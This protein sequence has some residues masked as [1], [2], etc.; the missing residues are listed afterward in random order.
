MPTYGFNTG[1]P[2]G[3]QSS[4][5]IYVKKQVRLD[6]LSFDQTKMFKLGNVAVAAV[7]NRLS[8]AQGP[9]DTAAK[10]L[11]KRYAI[12]KTKRGKGNRRNL[13]L[14]GDMLR[15]F[16]VRTV[17]ENRARAYVT[18]RSTSK[19]MWSKAKR[20]RFVG[21]E[22]KVKA[23][24]MQKIEPWMVLSPKNRASVSE[25]ARRILREMAKRLTVERWLG[26]K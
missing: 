18:G 12:W 2:Y 9:N 7:K 13:S 10:P 15:N 23:W 26:G 1:G 17:S 3:R 4:V 6:R 16:Q 25:A 22:N 14:S 5:R 8:L 24:A 11:T 20:P 19:S 21:V